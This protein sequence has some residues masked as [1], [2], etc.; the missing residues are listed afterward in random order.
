MSSPSSLH[1]LA[2]LN[3][4]F[5]NALDQTLD[6]SPRGTGQDAENKYPVFLPLLRGTVSFTKDTIILAVSELPRGKLQISVI[7]IYG[8]RLETSGLEL[9][10]YTQLRCARKEGKW[11][12]KIEKLKQDSACK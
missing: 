9:D 5:Y 7:T 11:H 10:S 12:V 4:T 2:A 8:Q 3:G 6:L 1:V